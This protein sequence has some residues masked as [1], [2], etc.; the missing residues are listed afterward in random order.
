MVRPPRSKG[1]PRR[2]RTSANVRKIVIEENS[3]VIAIEGVSPSTF[4]ELLIERRNDGA[5]AEGF[6]GEIFRFEFSHG[7]MPR[8]KPRWWREILIPT[9]AGRLTF[10]RAHRFLED[11]ASLQNASSN[12]AQ[13]QSSSATL[14]RLGLQPGHAS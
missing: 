7:L 4:L 3:G 13:D 11:S 1:A 2:A 14:G 12:I 8:H 9:F 5:F 10:S 6:D